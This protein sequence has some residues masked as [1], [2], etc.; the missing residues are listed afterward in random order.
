[1][2][3]QLCE[4]KVQVYYLN[5]SAEDGECEVHVSGDYRTARG[6]FDFAS[7]LPG[8]GSV[9]MV[10]HAGRV[11]FTKGY[12]M[13]TIYVPAK[14][15]CYRWS[16]ELEALVPSAANESLYTLSRLK[17]ADWVRSHL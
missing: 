15:G 4:W 6:L 12:D 9:D 3:A 1:M 13:G 14:P 16:D 10:D 5:G 7:S 8:V 17:L 11:V 2:K